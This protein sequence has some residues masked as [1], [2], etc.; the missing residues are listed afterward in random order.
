MNESPTG[1]EAST[2]AS[3]EPTTQV[4]Q[5]PNPAESQNQETISGEQSQGTV[6]QTTATNTNTNTE[7]SGGQNDDDGL[8]KFAKSQGFDPENMTDGEKRAL[9]IAHDNQ[10]AYR[11]STNEAKVTDVSKDLNTPKPDATEEE[12]FR[13]EF[14]QFKYEQQTNQF[15]GESKDG[16]AIRDKTLEPTMVQILN[17][18]KE[19]YGADYARTLSQDLPTLYDLARLKNGANLGPDAEAIRR[20]ERESIRQR[21]NASDGNQHAVNQAQGNNPAKIDRNWLETQYD[22]SNEEHRKL[23]DAAVARGDLY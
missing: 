21:A 23:V 9:K 7:N 17:E 5:T 2:V 11:N 8:A 13:S 6:S 4:Q 14:R 1:G 3:T 19:Q 18:K 16:V 22:P 12:Q 10:K 15:W 20:E